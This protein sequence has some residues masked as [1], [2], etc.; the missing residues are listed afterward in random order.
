MK[1]SVEQKIHYTLRI[2]CAMC[3][4]G[5]GAFGIIGKEIWAN[6]FAV[7]GI[8]HDAAFRLMPYVGA[9]DILCGMIILFYPVR[10]VILWLVIWGMITALLRPLSGEPFPE[11]IERAGNFAAPLALLILCGRVNFKNIFSPVSPVIFPKEKY[12]N[13]LRLCLQL[14][15]FLLLSGHGWLNLID[16]N[17]L[18]NEYRLLGFDDPAQTALVIGVFEIAGAISF[19]ILPLR[20]VVLF[21]FM[22]KMAAELLYPHYELFEFLERGGSYGILLAMWFTLEILPVM[23][24]KNE[25]AFA[26]YFLIND[27]NQ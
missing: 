8:G 23:K 9:I 24:R 16:K 27:K 26:R 7:F 21:F 17:S 6:Y 20:S 18:L 15:A 3:F 2:A 1:F 25:N 22:W 19:L 10:A 12:R 13:N 5:H 11:F 14:A 4:I